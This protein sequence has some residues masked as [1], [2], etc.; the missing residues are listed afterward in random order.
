M[1]LVLYNLY[2]FKDESHLLKDCHAQRTKTATDISVLLCYIT[3][4]KF[5]ISSSVW[6]LQ[7]YFGMKISRGAFRNILYSSLA[8]LFIIYFCHFLITFITQRRA[9]R[10][11]LL[12]GTPA[13]S[14]PAELFSQVRIIDPKIFPNYRD[15]A[16]RYCDGKQGK[17]SFEAKGCTNSDELSVI[18]LGSVMLR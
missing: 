15:F 18:L 2:G 8:L 12:T 6:F 4:G 5:V 1:T 13:L 3:F 14:R 7:F 10:V 11:I 17:Y 16:I 9:L